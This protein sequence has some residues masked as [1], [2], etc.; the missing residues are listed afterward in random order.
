MAYSVEQ[1]HKNP[2]LGVQDLVGNANTWPKFIRKTF[3]DR[4]F[5][6]HN[7]MIIVN[8]AYLNAISEEF[9]HEILSFTLKEAYTT[10]RKRQVKSRYA[11]LNDEVIFLIFDNCIAH[12]CT[13]IY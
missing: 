11:Y 12:K 2:W 13:F 8:F 6:D 5:K 7:R 3:W 10:D 1:I 4:N 9:L